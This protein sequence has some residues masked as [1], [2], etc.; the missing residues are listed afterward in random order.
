[1]KKRL[2]GETVFQAVDVIIM[3]IFIILILVPVF[4]VVM[5]SFISEAEIARR[6]SFIIIPEKFDFTA[7]EMLIASGKNILRAYKNTLF[8]VLTGTFLSL[9]VTI[10]LG[11]GLSRPQ[12]KGRT[13]ITGFPVP[14][15]R[16]SSSS[17]ALS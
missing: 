1:M 6:G 3:C 14:R 9:A 12:L 13:V 8:R 2:S 17:W 16:R 4:T 5:T 15:S 7:Y 11:Y 10:G